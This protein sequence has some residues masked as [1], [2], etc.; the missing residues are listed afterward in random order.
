MSVRE[1]DHQDAA[2]DVNGIGRRGFVGYVIGGTTLVAAA[3]LAL[4]SSGRAFAGPAAPAAA[5]TGVRRSP[6]S[7]TS[8]TSS[9]TRACRPPS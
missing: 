7:T 1:V 3:D 6:S 5:P 9:P 8:T 2:D 4:G